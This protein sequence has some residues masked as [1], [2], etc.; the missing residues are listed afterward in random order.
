MPLL[1]QYSVLFNKAGPPT[2]Y[3]YHIVR[4]HGSPP[5]TVYV[6]DYHRPEYSSRKH[7]PQDLGE[8]TEYDQSAN[9][10]LV[11][12]PSKTTI[13]ST[14]ESRTC[15]IKCFKLISY[16]Y[17]LPLTMTMHN[18]SSTIS[19]VAVAHLSQ[20]ILHSPIYKP[21]PSSHQFRK[22]HGTS[23]LQANETEETLV[24]MLIA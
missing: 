21:C 9:R 17:H 18:D 4:V 16:T 8:T 24:E 1:P 22:Q 5:A 20:W 7:F 19:T 13:H 12:T 11:E 6:D 14:I 2:D 15:G 23:K 10:Y 3:Y